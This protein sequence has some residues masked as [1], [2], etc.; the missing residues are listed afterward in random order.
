MRNRAIKI[1]FWWI[2]ILVIIIA[3]TGCQSEPML[4]PTV[5]N[6]ATAVPTSTSTVTPTVTVIPTNTS[7]PQPTPTA[8]LVPI[9]AYQYIFDHEVGK[10][11]CDL[12][13]WWGINI[14]D[15]LDEAY[16]VLM[17]LESV[18]HT[19]SDETNAGAAQF[20]DFEKCAGI[21]TM[22][23]GTHRPILCSE[24]GDSIDYI[25]LNFFSNFQP[26][27]LMLSEDWPN[28]LPGTFLEKYGEPDDLWVT[29]GYRED[30][31]YL[32]ST[33]FFYQDFNTII[34]IDAMYKMNMK[35]GDRLVYCPNVIDEQNF[36]GPY[37]IFLHMANDD[38][39]DTLVQS[40]YEDRQDSFKSQTKHDIFDQYSYTQVINSIKLNEV[41]DQNCLTIMVDD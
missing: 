5:V 34:E 32:V 20:Y 24:N 4:T 18:E 6:T 14:G 33:I 23:A 3:I 28:F 15:P 39:Y 21:T 16:E 27:G 11:S 25:N 31:Q 22:Y 41:D 13:C 26:Y 7:T 30:F 36:G 17:P 12:P 10:D 40:M 8:T 2:A 1:L 35:T 9:D 38:I 37:G 29:Y 19:L